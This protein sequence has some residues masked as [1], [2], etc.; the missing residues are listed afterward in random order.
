VGPH[1]TRHL[2]TAG[3]VAAQAEGGGKVRGGS[4]SVGSSGSAGA[5]RSTSPLKSG[6]S[7]VRDLGAMAEEGHGADDDGDDDDDDE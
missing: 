6:E 2:V 5:S 4:R 7:D 1:C 3:A